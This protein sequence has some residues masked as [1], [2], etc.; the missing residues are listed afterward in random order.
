MLAGVVVAESPRRGED[1]CGVV[2]DGISRVCV[3]VN[4]VLAALQ[5]GIRCYNEGECK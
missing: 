2:A 5:E 1:G 3:V 4:S